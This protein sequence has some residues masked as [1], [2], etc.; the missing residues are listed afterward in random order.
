MDYGKPAG[1]RVTQS[2]LEPEQDYVVVLP[3]EQLNTFRRT[4]RIRIPET[5]I[6]SCDYTTVDALREYI[7]ALTARGEKVQPI[8]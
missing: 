1:Q 8:E 7:E 2:N 4:L 6:T 5:S 3:A